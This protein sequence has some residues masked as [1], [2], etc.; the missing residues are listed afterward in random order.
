MENY[1]T[2][3][4]L[5]GLRGSEG[6]N[7]PLFKDAKAKRYQSLQRI[8]DLLD[9][10]AKTRPSLPSSIITL[11]PLD[12][13]TSNTQLNGT[14]K[15]PSQSSTEPAIGPM[16]VALPLFSYSSTHLVL[17]LL[18]LQCFLRQYPLQN[19]QKPFPFSRRLHFR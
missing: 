2:F 13:R 16:E 12:R 10:A 18:Q 6:G 7:L 14:I 17:L 3:T 1:F 9:V 11:N 4:T 8:V 15:C 19:L 5:L